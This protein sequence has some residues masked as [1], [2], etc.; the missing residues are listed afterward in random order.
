MN[1]RYLL[2]GDVLFQGSIGRYDLPTGSRSD[3]LETL[4]KIKRIAADW[5]VFPGHGSST[6]LQIELQVNPYLR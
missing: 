4:D 3:T 1:E 5:I 2:S 6:T